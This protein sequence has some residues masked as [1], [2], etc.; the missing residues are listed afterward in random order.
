MGSL[1]GLHVEDE[2]NMFIHS[3]DIF[4]KLQTISFHS[5]RIIFYVWQSMRSFRRLGHIACLKTMDYS[6]ERDLH[7]LKTVSKIKI[8]SVLQTYWGK[9]PSD[10]QQKATAVG[11]RAACTL[12]EMP[13]SHKL[14]LPVSPPPF[15]PFRGGRVVVT[16]LVHPPFQMASTTAT[17]KQKAP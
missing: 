4:S 11:T 15:L 6:K 3:K 16:A 17:E 13:G 10:T 8:C 12:A 1:F 5:L 7:V 14:Q 9:C 2:T